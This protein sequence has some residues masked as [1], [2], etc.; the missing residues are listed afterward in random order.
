[1]WKHMISSSQPCFVC[2][3]GKFK[4]KLICMSMYLLWFSA[5]SKL[6]LSHQFQIIET[7]ILRLYL[8]YFKLLTVQCSGVVYC[9]TGYSFSLTLANKEASEKLELMYRVQS[10]GTYERVAPEWMREVVNSVQACAWY[11]LT[12]YLTENQIRKHPASPSVVSCH[13]TSVL[14]TTGTQIQCYCE[15]KNA[16]LES[17][18]SVGSVASMLLRQV[19]VRMDWS[20]ITP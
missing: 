10:L 18:P 12:E 7:Q 3:L 4:H 11:F 15:L 6:F 5:V 19:G 17:S 1:M 14:L 2:R 8:M 16:V 20:K 9:I 13:E